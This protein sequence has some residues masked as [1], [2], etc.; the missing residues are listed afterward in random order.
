MAKGKSKKTIKVSAVL[1]GSGRLAENMDKWGLATKTVAKR[2]VSS[3]SLKIAKGAAE[4]VV[5]DRGR[6]RSS[7]KPRFYQSGLTADIVADVKYAPFIEFGT[8]PRGKQMTFDSGPLPA[9]YI[10]GNG[11]KMPP[12]D[13]IKEWITR[14]GISP[15]SGWTLDG[16]AYIVAKR[17]GE[18]GLPAR[19][20]LYPAF[21]DVEDAF[22]RR[23]KKFLKEVAAER[24]VA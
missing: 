17:I 9:G 16:F 19:P 7:I 15:P 8:G 18:N 3:F 4:R 20:F 11:G 22:N 5:V 14:K 1:E 6:L 10:H 23:V 12:V 21:R 2:I 13:L 24:G